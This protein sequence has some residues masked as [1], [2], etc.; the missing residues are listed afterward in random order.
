[1]AHEDAGPHILNDTGERCIPGRTEMP[2][3]YEHVHRY[4]LAAGIVSG[5]DVID[6]G[7]GAGYGAEMLSRTAR[8]VVGVDI[9]EAAIAHRKSRYEGGSV[10]FVHES[11][12]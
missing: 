4:L 2:T 1:M 9:D 10:S 5:C 11:A 3:Y 7:S 8:S 6:V 12:V